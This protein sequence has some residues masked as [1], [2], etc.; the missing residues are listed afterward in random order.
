MRTE[1]VTE[2]PQFSG[3]FAQSH[4]GCHQPD[5]TKWLTSIPYTESSRV[6]TALLKQGKCPGDGANQ[7]IAYRLRDRFV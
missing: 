2:T 4:T 1:A 6:S 3:T 5:F 7:A